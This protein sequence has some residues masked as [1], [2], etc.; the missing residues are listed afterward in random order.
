MTKQNY[1]RMWRVKLKFSMQELGAKA[2]VS[3]AT[4]NTIERNSHYPG[5]EVRHRLVTVLGISENIIWPNTEV[6][7]RK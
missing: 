1:L 3:P 5:P 2:G 7:E 4:I 6:M